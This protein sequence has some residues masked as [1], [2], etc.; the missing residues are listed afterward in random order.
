MEM[1]RVILETRR[2]FLGDS[3]IATGEACFVKG[4]L[5]QL[6]Q[7]D[8]EAYALYSIALHTYQTQLGAEHA[9]TQAI[10]RALQS[11]TAAAPAGAHVGAAG[12]QSANWASLNLQLQL[13]VGDAASRSEAH[14]YSESPPNSPPLMVTKE[15]GTVSEVLAIHDS[16][17]NED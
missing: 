2:K 15:H 11:V 6:L 17:V 13:G 3:D 8:S 7:R 14:A 12:D 5:K 16:T 1:L 9:S 10:R 4:I